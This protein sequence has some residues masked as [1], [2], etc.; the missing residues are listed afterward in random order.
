MGNNR[1]LDI[2]Q[3]LRPYEHMIAFEVCHT[4]KKGQ[5]LSSKFES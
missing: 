5:K 1:F 2:E 4:Q 3:A